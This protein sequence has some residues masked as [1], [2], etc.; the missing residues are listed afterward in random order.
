MKT[1]K[2]LLILAVVL[3][4]IYYQVDKYLFYYGKNDLHIYHSLPFKIVAEDR[5]P[6][7]GGFA[8]RD[9]YEGFTIAAKGNTY[10]VDN[11]QIL[12][13]KVLKYGFSPEHLVVVV[14]DSNGNRYYIEFKRKQNDT[15]DF[16]AVMN[17]DNGHYN[18]NLDKWVDIEGNDA[19]AGKLALLRNYL[20]FIVI[21]LLLTLIYKL[22]GYRK[23]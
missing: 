19:Y 18:S 4:I 1:F 12:I 11:K 14:I 8:L 6:F 3:G 16:N 5:P 2:I 23:I 9:E 7:E 21:I 20:M 15:S 22:I 13:N 10:P 17:I